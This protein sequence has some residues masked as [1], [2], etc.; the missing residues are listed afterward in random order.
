MVQNNV[1]NLQ[2][3]KP[4]SVHTFGYWGGSG[5]GLKYCSACVEDAQNSQRPA[6][7]GG[8]RFGR[9]VTAG[10]SV[11]NERVWRDFKGTTVQ[12]CTHLVTWLCCGE[13]S[14]NEMCVFLELCFVATPAALNPERFQWHGGG[15]ISGRNQNQLTDSSF[16]RLHLQ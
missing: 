13:I 14:L 5:L 1:F 16:S 15:V 3:D 7:F 9:A 4:L 2:H 6:K 11:C 10:L 12:N 8:Q